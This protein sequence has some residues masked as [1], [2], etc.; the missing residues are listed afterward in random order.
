MAT[1]PTPA[2][3]DT[4]YAEAVAYA[5]ADVTHYDTLTFASSLDTDSVRIVL[6]DT[7]LVTPQGTY[8]PCDAEFTPAETEGGIVGRL[9]I[10]INYL[11]PAALAWLEEASSAGAHL[12][13]TWRQYLGTGIDPDFESRL[14]LSIIGSEYSNGQCTLTATLPD[15]VNL[16][17]GRKLMT[18]RILPGLAGR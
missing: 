4:A 12:T 13:V 2:D 17:F 1:Q 9:E 6:D 16:P 15:L 3:F 10:T 8:I 7:A 11:P 14:P 18:S 5:K